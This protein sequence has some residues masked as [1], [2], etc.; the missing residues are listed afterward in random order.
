MPRFATTTRIK[1]TTQPP[2]SNFNSE[3]SLLYMAKKIGL[4][5]D[6][7]N[8]LTL[9][10]LYDLVDMWI[11]EEDNAPREATQEDIDRFYRVM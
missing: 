4:S 9:Q 3:I 10:D 5:F 11:G 8:Q 6:E 2:K 7:L 1:K